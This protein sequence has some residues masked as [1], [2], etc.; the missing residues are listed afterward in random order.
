MASKYKSRKVEVDGITFHSAKEAKRYGELKLLEKAGEIR[1][2]VLQPRFPLDV[3]GVKVAT[4]VADFKYLERDEDD[5][6]QLVVEDVKGF[7]TPVYRLK[8][9]LFS[10]L[11]FFPIRE[12]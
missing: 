8:A 9:K 7:R 2:L 5:L 3:A 6:W 12:V 10:A 11:Y 4:Y 1:E